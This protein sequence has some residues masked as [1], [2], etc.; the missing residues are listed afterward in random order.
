M[1]KDYDVIIIGAGP[2]GLEA[3]AY[4][5]K[6]GAKVVVLEKRYEIGGGLATD[7][8]LLPGYLYNTHAIYMMMADYAPVYKDFN[9]EEY[10]CKHILP[11]VQFAMP[12]SDGRAL[13]LY[14]DVEKTCESIAQ[15]SKKDAE[16]YREFHALAKRAFDEIIGPGTY[17]PA[18]PTLDA[19]IHMQETEL[20]RTVM[21]F[22]ESTPQ[23]IIEA[24]FENEHVRALFLYI[25]C[26]WGV[27]YDQ[28]G[29]GFLVL[30]YFNRATNYQLTRGGSHAVASVLAKIIHEN[31]GMALD[32]QRIKR[33]LVKDGVCS[34][35]EMENGDILNAKAVISSIDPHQTFL[36]LVG[37][38]NLEEE[39]VE[40]IKGWQWEKTSLLTVH[41]ALSEAPN[42]IA[43]Q[44]NPDVNNALVCLLGLETE[45]DVLEYFDAVYRGEIPKKAVFT[46][47]FPSLHDPTQAPPGRCS[48]LIT[49]EVPY[50]LKEGG[51]ERWYNIKFQEEQGEVCLA[52][53]K[54]YAPNMTEDT[55][56]QYKVFT[57]KGME[58][59]FADMVEGSFKQGA[60]QPLQ[61]GYQ[62]PNDECSQQATPVKNLYL[63]GSSCYPGG[64]VIWGSGYLA[65]NKVA[66]DLGIKKWWL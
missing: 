9:F 66:D 12:L 8:L 45:K 31:G 46:C 47:S 65:A 14:T 26:M 62:R 56:W 29:L 50:N 41:M 18:L 60:Y 33:I 16:S 21:K 10:N 17:V 15:F 53:L 39:F 1:E 59:K 2:N 36:K 48:G 27:E 25:C 49:R 35:L 6:A 64:C 22:S 55:I 32:S 61:M 52:T 5:A 11:P 54:K 19:V 34:G 7:E 42:F 44:K 51:P 43:A 28:S 4:L 63:G 37:E 58:D 20:G 40:K 23:E 24:H 3:G 57:P 38:Q 13:C 30:L